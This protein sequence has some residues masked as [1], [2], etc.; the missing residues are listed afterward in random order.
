MPAATLNQI[1]R[2]Q[3]E[4]RG[5]KVALLFEGETR[6]YAELDRHA[7]QIANGLIAK[8]V[9]PG[10]RVAYLGKNTLAY[11]EFL[12]G[13]AKACA[14]TVPVNWRLA[15]PEVRYILENARPKLL[16]VEP[17]FE[18]TAANAAPH[19]EQLV[20]GGAND[21]FVSWRER[22]SDAAVDP[23]VD[24]EEPL[25]QLYTSGTTGRPK[26]AVLT[27]RSMFSLRSRPELLP[28]WYLWAPEDVSL[29]AMPIA[30]I[31]G[32]GW[33]VWT[34][35][36]GATGVILREFDPHKV[37]DLMV[38]KRVTKIMMVPTAMQIAVRHPLA[39][40]TDFSF[41]RYMFYG[42]APLPVDLMKECSQVFGCG[43]VQMYGMTET[44]GTVV[45]LGPEDHHPGCARSAR[46]CRG[47]KSKSSMPGGRRS[48]A[49]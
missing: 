46:R 1:L 36:H 49:A 42:G 17:A 28:E 12:L 24:P 22:Q 20:T 34:L 6:S 30:H 32:T 9:V 5:A 39:K 10:D 3:V 21:T 4:A 7:A 41:L 40:S 15:E 2:A 31:S 33:G 47:W 11:F 45:A 13:A 37:F 18:S 8:G 14:V 43:F 26:G 38:S 16:L 23:T 48:S 44:S 25:L 19:T 27:H 29:I 35:H